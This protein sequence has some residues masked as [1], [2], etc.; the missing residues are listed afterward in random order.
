MPDPFPK[1]LPQPPP[2]FQPNS[3]PDVCPW[4]AHPEAEHSALVFS[5][6]QAHANANVHCQESHAEAQ[7]VALRRAY[8]VS[9]A[10]AHVCR[11]QPVSRAERLAF[12]RPHS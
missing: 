10:C 12:E 1:P 8:C 11:R 5:L 3:Y 7:S 4:V 2:G 9:Y 6:S